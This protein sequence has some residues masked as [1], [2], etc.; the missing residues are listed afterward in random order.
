LFRDGAHLA[1][2]LGICD[3]EV[4]LWKNDRDFLRRTAFQHVE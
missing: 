3:P 1:E 2:Q 4:L